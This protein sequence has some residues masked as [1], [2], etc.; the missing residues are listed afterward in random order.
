MTDKSVLTV[1][2]S[3][4]Y[5]PFEV[6][7][8]SGNIVGFDMDFMDWMAKDLGIQKKVVALL[9]PGIQSGQAMKSKKCDVAAAAMTIT[10]ERKAGIT[11]SDPYY[12]ASQALMVLS[13]SSV[14]GL[15]DLKGKKLGAQ[16][17]TTG[18][19]YANK[20]A[21][22]YGYS[23]LQYTQI[24]D[25]EQA[26]VSHKIDAAIHDQPA[27]NQ[28]VKQQA[29]KAKV[30]ANFNTGEQYG[31]GMALGNT[32]LTKV[33][34]YAIAQALKDGTYKSSFMKWIGGTPPGKI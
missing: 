34:N 5:P 11:F 13:D 8:G 19:L 33:A 10:A 3:L 1:C 31:F 9:F 24:S 23:V 14:K 12:D 20:Y 7:D 16:T 28:Y 17:G 22:Q 18:L 21:A 4:P 30:V 27:L 29:G 15:A 2:T 6:D 25:E 32:A 26:L